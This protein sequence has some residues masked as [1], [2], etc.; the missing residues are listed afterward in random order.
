VRVAAVQMRLRLIG[1]TAEYAQMIAARARD[2]AALGA[3]LI[4]FPEDSGTHLVGLLPGLDSLPDDVSLAQATGAVAGPS[5]RPAE[6]LR[7]IGPAVRTAYMATFSEVARRLGV[8]IA[9]GSA[10]L[11]DEHGAVLNV[12]YLFGPDGALLGHQ[13]KCHLLPLEASW[14]LEAGDDLRVVRTPAGALGFPIC[15][16][17]TYFETTRILAGLG[18]EVILIPACDVQEDR[19]VGAAGCAAGAAGTAPDPYNAWK[20][21][22]GLWPRVQESLTYGIHAAMVGRF[23]GMTITGRSAILAPVELT[24]DGSGILAQAASWDQEEVVVADLDYGA[25]HELWRTSDVEEGFN[26]ALYRKHFPGA[27]AEYLQRHPGGRR[28]PVPHGTG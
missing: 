19:A 27:Y 6:I 21:L 7:F 12:G 13:E 2:A 4:V 24:P 9:S 16:D 25:L 18:A 28:F 3:Q 1:D 23:L 10:M 22:R 8:Y 15:M 26:L 11:P 20:A 5:V 17:A 14:G